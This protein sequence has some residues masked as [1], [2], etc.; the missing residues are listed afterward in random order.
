MLSG[1]DVEVAQRINESAW[2]NFQPKHPWRL[3]VV[4]LQ[5]AQPLQQQE[6]G[7]ED[8][9]LELL[10]FSEMVKLELSSSEQLRIMHAMP[11]LDGSLVGKCV[12]V[13][14]VDRRR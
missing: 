10:T 2:P 12:A 11:P 9:E 5:H 4:T 14:I 7:F 6:L 3:Y 8:P 1:A 13:R